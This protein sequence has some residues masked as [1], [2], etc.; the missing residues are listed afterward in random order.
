MK[1]FSETEP[2]W[3]KDLAEEVKGECQEKYGKVEHIKVER[4]SQ[5]R[6]LT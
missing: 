4:D 2:N 6:L 5:V 3:D 1:L